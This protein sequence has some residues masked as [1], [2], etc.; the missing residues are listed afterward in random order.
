MNQRLQKLS[1]PYFIFSLV[2]L[3]LNDWVFKYLFHNTLT[4]KLS[5]FAG[6]FAFPFFFS[7]LFPKQIKFVY[8]STFL[9][10]ILWKSEFSQPFIDLIN[11]KAVL[12]K[13]VVDYSDYIALVSAP[14]SYKIFIDRKIEYCKPIIAKAILVVS[15]VAFLATSMPRHLYKANKNYDFNFS[16]KEL[17]Q[18]FNKAQ[19]DNFSIYDSLD[20]RIIFDSTRNIY[21]FRNKTDTFFTAIDINKINDTLIIHLK[22]PYADVQICGNDSSSSLRL[23]NIIAYGRNRKKVKLKAE[24]SA[25]E[26][27]EKNFIEKIKSIKNN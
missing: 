27:F 17:V 7:A 26:S 15:C 16:K 19:R 14:I 18:R 10:F 11:Y 25:L 23:V 5:D 12:I 24:S 3:I 22:W 8:S 4:G 20:G 1:N 2:L 6:L 21:H 9:L 13:R